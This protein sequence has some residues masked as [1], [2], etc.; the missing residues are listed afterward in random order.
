MKNYVV[1]VLGSSPTALYVLKECD[2]LN[3]KTL[4]LDFNKGPSFYS[5]IPVEK[6]VISQNHFNQFCLTLLGAKINYVFI[7]TS[8]EWIVSIH[9]NRKLFKKNLI[10]SQSYLDGTYLDFYDKKNLY[11]LCGRHKINFPKTKVFRGKTLE[12]LKKKKS[13]EDLHQLIKHKIF[14]GNWDEFRSNWSTGLDMYDKIIDGI[15]IY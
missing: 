7:P 4:L 10:T 1:V 14:N 9:N 2:N 13:M 11:R 3:L 6:K 8:D 15:N 5:K 12:N